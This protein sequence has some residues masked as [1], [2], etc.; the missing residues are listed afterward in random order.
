MRYKEC[1]DIMCYMCTATAYAVDIN[2]SLGGRTDVVSVL[3]IVT[4]YVVLVD[5]LKQNNHDVE[6][7]QQK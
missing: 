4:V 1:I 7:A 6:L 5:C 3:Y 2:V